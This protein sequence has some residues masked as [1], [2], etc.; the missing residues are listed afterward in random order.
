MPTD[1]DL[2]RDPFVGVLQMGP[3]KAGK[4]VAAVGSAPKPVFILNADPKGLLSAKSMGLRFTYEDCFSISDTE[5]HVK[6]LQNDFR[7]SKAPFAT[8]VLD[9]VSLLAQ[10]YV[11]ELRS[12]GLEAWDLYRELKDRLLKVLVPLTQLPAH[13]IVNSHAVL[14]F[15]GEGGSMGTEPLIEGKVKTLLPALLADWVWLEVTTG[16]K[17][18]ETKREF[19]IGPQGNWKH[20]C[21][22]LKTSGRMPADFSLF[23]KRIAEGDRDSRGG[24]NR[25]VA[26]AKR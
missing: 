20:G 23:I 17:P 14:D 26:S 5:K 1:Q 22:S 25:V 18:E 13:L 12:R 19:L 15:K 9:T 10:T 3:P 16:A 2:A 24:N 6:A 4:T 7:S 11:S 21:R 8:V